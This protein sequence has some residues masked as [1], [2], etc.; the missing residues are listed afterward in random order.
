MALDTDLSLSPYFDDF[1]DDANQYAV[2]Y[3]PGVPVQARE[4]N[5][6]QSILQDQINKFG[7]S[8]YK[9][10][11]VIEGCAF[12]FDNKY[13]YVKIKDTYSNGSAFTISDFIGRVVTNSNGLKGLVVNAV[14]GFETQ[15]PDLNTLYIKYLNSGTYSNGAGQQAFSNTENLVIATSAN[16]AIG[17]VTV[18]TIANSA[19]YGYGMTVTDG[20]IFKKGYFIRVPS[21]TTIVTKYSNQ[22]NNVSVGFGVIEDIETPASNTHL[23][24]NAQGAP[25]YGA[26]GAHRLK[27]TPNLITRVTSDASNTAAFFS[28]CD[29]NS[30]RPVSIKNDPQYSALGTQ[31]AKRTFE[32]N[33]DF[34]VNPFLLTTEI[35]KANNDTANTS[36]NTTYLNLVSSPGLAYAKGYR[37]EFL[38]KNAVDLRKG[39]DTISAQSRVSANFGNYVFCNNFVGDFNTDNLAQVELHSIA[40]G[41]INNGTFLS[42]SYQSK[43]IGTAYIRG[44]EY[45]SGTPG[46]D[47]Q[48]IVYVFNIKMDAGYN[49]SQVKSVMYYPSSTVKAIGDVILT[50]DY[51]SNTN[52]AKL[53]ENTI[54]TMVFPL[55]QKA[56]K[57]DSFT[58][59]SFVYRNRANSSFDTAGNMSITIPAAAGT[60]TEVFTYGV[61]NLGQTELETFVVIPYQTGYTTNNA[62]TVTSSGNTLTGSG[63]SFTTAYRVGDVIRVANSTVNN[64][65]IITSITNSTYL[66]VNTALSP[67]FT[68]VN[69][70]QVF[71]AG[72]PL[73]MLNRSGRSINITSTTTANISLGI[74][75]NSAFSV[76]VYH[77]TLR[78]STIPI[79]KSI[80]RDT[81]VKIDTA[82]NAGGT[83]GPWCLGVSDAFKINHVW[84]STGSY[85]S[86]VVDSVS[87]FSLDNGQ[88][89]SYYDL[90]YLKS[91]MTALP[92][93]SLILVSVDHF[94]HDDSQGHG[95]FTGNSYPINDSSA[96]NSTIFTAE[97]PL[98][99]SPVKGSTFDLRDCVDFRPYVANTTV[100]TSSV[101]SATVN[102]NSTISFTGA[103]DSSIPGSLGSYL[104]SPN[105]LF[106]ANVAYYLPRRDR[107]SITT[108][109][110]LLITEGLSDP[111]P[112]APVE[113]P[114]TMSLGVVDVPPYP[115]LSALEAK[116][117]NRY[118]YVPTMN[119]SQIKRYAMSDI[120]ALADRI[121]NLEYY[122]SLSA[123]EQ[124]AA[125]LLVR[126][127]ATGQNR[128]KNGILVD[129][130]KG[131]DIGNTKHPQ[132]SIAV[133]SDRQEARP[134]FRQFNQELVVDET[135]S[136]GYKQR[137]HVITIDHV[138]KLIQSQSY[139]SKYHNCVEGNIYEWRGSVQLFPSG[140][141]Q[142][143][144]TV[145]PDVVNN[146]DLASNWINLAAQSSWGTK[147]NNWVTT[148]SSTTYGSAY[149][150]GAISSSTNSD[151]STTTGYA[152]QINTTTTLN[153]SRT[154]STLGINGVSN[155]ALNLGTFV[156]DISIKPYIKQKL[157]TFGA[158][159]LKPNTRVYPY[160]NNTRVDNYCV[161]GYLYTGTVNTVN[162]IKVDS[163]GNP[164]FPISLIEVDGTTVDYYYTAN[165]NSWGSSLIV[166]SDGRLQGAFLIQGE[167][168][169]NTAASTT[170]M[171]SGLAVSTGR[172]ILNTR[173]A[174]LSYSETIAHQTIQ[175]NGVIAGP[176]VYVTTAPPPV[177]SYDPG[178]SWTSYGGF[179]GDHDGSGGNAGVGTGP[180][181]AAAAAGG[182]DDGGGAS[183]ICTALYKLGYLPDHIYE[184]DD[185]FGKYLRDHD[186]DVY[187]GYLKWASK[188]V[189]F[190]N[191]DSPKFMF[192]IK[193]NKKRNNIQRKVIINLVR[194]IAT[195]WAKHMAYRMGVI[196]QDNN[197]GK[198]LMY[199]GMFIC[200]IIGRY[201]RTINTKSAVI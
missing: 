37:V 134:A 137:G 105:Q 104:I 16:V 167:S 65:R 186:P 180:G 18:A 121:S 94:T 54:S 56:V 17:N 13:A 53:E 90:A 4:M 162:N 29:F 87:S 41:A 67:A 136:T 9:E 150:T 99:T 44:I 52:I 130:F 111:N 38:N 128:F 114:G 126:S 64:D 178:L 89:D 156:T 175:Q 51:A 165:G 82:T 154:G 22:P 14:Q 142:P 92:P 116:T 177:P 24:D 26:P 131:H 19:G 49:F 35:K 12:S 102:P 73:S 164:L 84:V 45:Y 2:L 85:S 148:S 15:A 181:A 115:T 76:S 201:T 135:L 72:A 144:T 124:S 174:L 39:I 8:I 98:F 133:D 139:A 93:N 6:V 189:Y 170:Y 47:A 159:G 123:L 158:R 33:G 195:P 169:I 138:E 95:F 78:Q 100:I 183:V 132:Y 106:Q 21:Q 117:Y 161:Q 70:Q 187:Y 108:G 40:Y 86:S 129:P 188:V 112:R 25:N 193:D 42:T 141:L 185:R 110:E 182:G 81:L 198:L 30:G 103:T 143:D 192:W 152:T 80:T 171:A 46:A 127:G 61:G 31:L 173:Q 27:L 7:R 55:G 146:L 196:E 23:Y 119:L 155:T 101:G 190:M 145:S 11:S 149:Q 166:G 96:S 5:Q 107:I 28:I 97:I 43:K 68:S 48:Y 122:T 168:A 163:S 191:N 63:T 184:A 194:T 172:S 176:P 75:P 66:S 3:R 151:G 199:F 153:Q 160:F 57:V 109:G 1:S 32:T 62:G 10:G 140:D 125:S 77:D 118:D 50:Y 34:V 69:H 83:T 200:R 58:N 147:W 179:S 59:E 74:T 71:P 157:I 197:I 79:A 91:N 20:V 88:R 120:G 36:S 113:Q 60:G